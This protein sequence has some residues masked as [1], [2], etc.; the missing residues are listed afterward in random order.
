MK[1]YWTIIRK[2]LLS[3]ALILFLITSFIFLLLRIAPGD[4][5]QRFISPELS[6]L[7]LEKVKKSF[8]LDRSLLEQYV[9]FIKNI[10]IGDFGISYNYRMPVMSV[11]SNTLPFTL[12][13]ASIS[14][15]L[16][17]SISLLLIFFISQ[18]RNSF[19]DKLLSRLNLIFYSIPTMIVGMFLIYFFS[20]QLNLLPMSDLHS[21]Y[22]DNATFGDK[23]FDYA[24][25]MILPLATLSLSGI[26]V[27]YGYLRN[28]IDEVYKKSFVLFLRGCGMKESQIFKNHVLPN[29]IEPLIS[30]LGTE[31]GILLGGALI[32]ENIFGLPGMGRLIVDAIL[33]RD[34]PL[35]VGCVFVSTILVLIA[36]MLA[37]FVKVIIN[38]KLASEYFE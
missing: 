23:L 8:L 13:F 31:L 19:F 22:P 29:S 26:I 27:F 2:R 14:F 24:K 6:P 18:R 35:V 30:V 38:K 28:N 15:I 33:T 5:T 10:F 3:T 9:I 17:I 36:N 34:Y 4:P 11:I 21:M 1:N 7:L 16:Q 32:T 37:D 12:I 20:L 25:H